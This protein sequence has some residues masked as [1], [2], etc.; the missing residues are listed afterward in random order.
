MS[1]RTKEQYEEIRETSSQKILMAA[2]E[3]F[4]THG[5]DATSISELAKHAGVSKGLIYN[6]FHSKKHLL[7]ELVKSLNQK[8]DKI[9][10]KV[11]DPD[12]A[13]MLE[14]IFKYF[15]RELKMN[16]EQWKLIASLAIQVG[17]YDFIHQQA[18]MKIDSYYQ[19]FENLLKRIGVARPRREAKIIAALMDG[20]GFQYIVLGKDYPMKEIEKFLID[21]YRDIKFYNIKY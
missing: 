19:L 9:M 3:L 7:E 13:I 8:E 2:L 18:L 10:A 11:M 14:K 1:P 4:A 6:Y 17:K 20:I 5:Y 21:K 12:P 16:T 15:F